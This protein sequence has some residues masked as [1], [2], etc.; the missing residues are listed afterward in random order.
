VCDPS[1][2]GITGSSPAG[3]KDMY[4]V[5][6]VCCQVEVSASSR[7]LVQRS[8]TEC[9]VPE[10]N[11]EASSARRPW[12]TGPHKSKLNTNQYCCFKFVK[13]RNLQ[14]RYL[15]IILLPLD[16]ALVKKK[17][18]ICS[19]WFNWKY[20]SRLACTYSVKFRRVRV[21]Y[22]ACVNEALSIHLF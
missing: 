1:F 2:A 10:C 19:S 8:P 13:I 5:S 14:Q 7:S 12:P 9:G 17:S 11:G 3:S 4:F 21:T 18:E 16:G 20:K 15:V 6:V 22:S